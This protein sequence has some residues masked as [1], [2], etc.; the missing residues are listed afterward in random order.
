MDQT[1]GGGGGFVIISATKFSVMF[2][3][4]GKKHSKRKSLLNEI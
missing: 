3:M 4:S 2:R 1:R